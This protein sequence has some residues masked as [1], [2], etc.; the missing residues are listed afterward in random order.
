M[1]GEAQDVLEH[2]DAALD[3]THDGARGIASRLL[4]ERDDL[5]GR[6]R[7]P[8]GLPRPPALIAVAEVRTLV[9]V[10]AQPGVEVGLQ[11]LDAPVEG[12][13]PRGTLDGWSCPVLVG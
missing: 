1:V 6:L 2:E 10:V 9:V 8:A 4:R 3:V 12:E 7:V 5:E 13:R 11:G